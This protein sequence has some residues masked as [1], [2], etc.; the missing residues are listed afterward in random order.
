MKVKELL[1][2]LSQLVD[3]DDLEVNAEDSFYHSFPINDAVLCEDAFGN[4][5]VKLDIE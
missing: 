3:A 4:K 2:K 5:Y 1:V